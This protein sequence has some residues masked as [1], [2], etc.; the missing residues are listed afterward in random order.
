MNA[1]SANRKFFDVT[2]QSKIIKALLR[3][4]S[5]H[6]I[7]LNGGRRIALSSTYM[8]DENLTDLRHLNGKLHIPVTK[9]AS[10]SSEEEDDILTKLVRHFLANPKQILPDDITMD[11]K[12]ETL[13]EWIEKEHDVIQLSR[14]IK[15]ILEAMGAAA[16]FAVQQQVASLQCNQAVM[17]E[18]VV[19]L[20]DSVGFLQKYLVDEIEMGMQS[21]Q[22]SR[23]RTDSLMTG[24]RNCERNISSPSPSSGSSML[25]S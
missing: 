11:D 19:V 10:P 17:Q 25:S 7:T 18:D 5:Q 4:P 21:L 15:L 1:A 22:Y 2:D 12:V 14:R 20:Q 9:L 13:K 8:M 16:A 23:I 6:T 24:S 3:N